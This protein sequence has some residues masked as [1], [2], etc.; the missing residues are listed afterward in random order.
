MGEILKAATFHIKPLPPD[1]LTQAYAIVQPFLPDLD[2]EIVCAFLSVVCDSI[3]AFSGPVALEAMS[4]RP[5]QSELEPADARTVREAYKSCA[6]LISKAMEGLPAQKFVLASLRAE[7]YLNGARAGAFETSDSEDALNADLA[8]RVFSVTT[9][10]RARALQAAIT[11]HRRARR[12][13]YLYQAFVQL[14]STV[15]RARQSYQADRGEE[16]PAVTRHKGVRNSDRVED[17]D[18]ASLSSAPEG[19][20]WGQ[21]DSRNS[22]GVISPA[23]A[24]EVEKICSLAS[25]SFS[26]PYGRILAQFMDSAVLA[27]LRAGQRAEL[28]DIITDST[29]TYLGL[30]M[31]LEPLQLELYVSL[32]QSVIDGNIEST[33]VLLERLTQ[34]LR[35]AAPST[36]LE[37]PPPGIHADD[38]VAFLEPEI[39]KAIV[40]RARE[41]A[42]VNLL[43]SSPLSER[44]HFPLAQVGEKLQIDDP[45]EVQ[46]VCLGC[47]SKGMIA[48]RID[49]VRKV[50]LV[51]RVLPRRPTEDQ[52]HAFSTRLSEWA[53]SIT[54][55]V[56]QMEEGWES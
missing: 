39:V 37:E 49:G 21:D 43:F 25:L 7:E 27:C 55:T 40:F 56:S 38:V 8:S 11:R 51:E 2:P 31:N 19:E 23:V 48:G 5:S 29:R 30:S 10:A 41:A 22:A 3:W 26:A 45:L 9:L 32:L 24:S 50:L 20:P 33:T 12:D 6:T 4:G 13:E 16:V 1:G 34:S 17:G 14:V 52:L 15:D 54:A 36:T 42:L 18:G 53:R 44:T 46:R 47:L 28:A 35:S